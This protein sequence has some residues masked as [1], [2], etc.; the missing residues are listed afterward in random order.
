MESS[1]EWN[2]KISISFSR[3]K[4]DDWFISVDGAMAEN[5][6]TIVKDM[7]N[8]LDQ[9]EADPL[10]GA[11]EFRPDVEPH[12]AEDGTSHVSEMSLAQR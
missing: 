7:D 9:R 1:Q 10:V 3:L 4:A 11:A 2:V 5:P 12:T 8:Q 6:L